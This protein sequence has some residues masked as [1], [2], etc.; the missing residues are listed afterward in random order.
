[1]E[2]IRPYLEK[3][4][5]VQRRV[6]LQQFYAQVSSICMSPFVDLLR[7]LFLQSV[8]L[9]SDVRPVV[10]WNV[11]YRTINYDKALTMMADVAWDIKELAS[12]HSPYVEHL[13]KVRVIIV[14]SMNEF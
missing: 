5:P 1:M 4:L 2:Q 14:S 10:Y 13:V 11:A 6:F 9:V 12:Q 3:A 7:F 8:S